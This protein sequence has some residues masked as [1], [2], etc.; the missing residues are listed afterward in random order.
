MAQQSKNILSEIQGVESE[1]EKEVAAIDSVTKLETV[2][3][4]FLSKKGKLQSLFSHLGAL[5][6]QE[7]P[8]VGAELNRLKNRIQEDLLEKKSALGSAKSPV[9]SF[10][11]TLPGK[12]PSFGTIHP[13][14]QVLGEIENIFMGMGFRVEEGPEI[15]TEF[16]NFEA[17]NIPEDHPSR[18]M[19]D[20]F[21]LPDNYLL[22]THTSPVQI[23]TMQK[24][25]PPVR[26]IA[27]G[28]CFRRDTPDAT[29][30]PTFHQ[31][32][33]LCVD[34]GVSFADLKGVIMAFARKLFD[35][36]VKV[37]FRPGF[38]PFTEP[39]AEYDFSCI[40]CS[41]QGCRVC[42]NTGWLEISGAGMVDPAVFGFVDY[43]P[44]IYTGYAFG[45]GV[46]RIAMLKY[47]VHDIRIFYENDLRFLRQF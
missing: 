28:R 13:L 25:R 32:E 10:D 30:S 17:L 46:E 15:E 7:R 42:K 22:R 12:T 31:V 19:Q 3:I 4:V 29:H 44:A 40:F 23:R 38:F 1:F 21:Y 34:K 37:R 39:S 16:Y 14:M 24:Q 35:A 5:D 43:D 8:L 26:M 47:Q 36:E 6:P 33:G 18:D 41:G 45:M 2:R 9:D 27:P 11:P 20:T